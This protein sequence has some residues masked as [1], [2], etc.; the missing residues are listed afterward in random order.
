MN[1]EEMNL[2]D[3]LDLT[4][5]LGIKPDDTAFETGKSYLIRTVTLYYTGR[6]KRITSKELVLEEAAW[7]P[8][9]G[10]FNECLT[11]GKFNE[12]EPFQNDVIIPRDSIIDGTVWNHKLPRTVK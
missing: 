2:K 11:D 9:T 6:I 4:K 7:I 12:V 10:R 8:D 1:L 3:I 5:A